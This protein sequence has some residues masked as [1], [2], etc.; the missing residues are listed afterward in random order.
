[1]GGVGGGGEG[2]KD[3]LNSYLP[4]TSTNVGISPQNFLPFSFNPFPT[5]A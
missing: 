5:L 4:V 2:Q 3:P 1:M